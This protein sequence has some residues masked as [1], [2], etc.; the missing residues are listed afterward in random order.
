VTSVDPLKVT[1]SFTNPK[2]PGW[3]FNEVRQIPKPI[4]L[5]VGQ[6]EVKNGEWGLEMNFTFVFLIIA[7]HFAYRAS[8]FVHQEVPETG[9]SACE[10]SLPPHRDVTFH[11]LA[12][13][14]ALSMAMTHASVVADFRSPGL[15]PWRYF[16]RLAVSA[17]LALSIGFANG[18]QMSDIFLLWHL[19]LVLG[20]SLEPRLHP[21]RNQ[22]FIG[23]LL[24]PAS[25][26]ELWHLTFCMALSINV[27]S[28]LRR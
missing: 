10:L 28:M 20:H 2:A 6:G 9:A 12:C 19:V 3:H 7:A 5:K 25:S 1:I 22:L 15:V 23:G 16:G 13:A 11:M 27:C 17:F 18:K 26:W 4:G 14:G 21:T 8:A 24:S